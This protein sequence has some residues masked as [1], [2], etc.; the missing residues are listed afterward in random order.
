MKTLFSFGYVITWLTVI[1][2]LFMIYLKIEG[3]INI[4]WWWVFSPVLIPLAAVFGLLIFAYLLIIMFF[5]DEDL[6]GAEDEN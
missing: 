6:S 2:T 1:A 4:S 5:K 3:S